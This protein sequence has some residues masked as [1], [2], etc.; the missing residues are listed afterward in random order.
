MILKEDLM[1]DGLHY[2]LKFDHYSFSFSLNRPPRARVQIN[3]RKHPELALFRDEPI[4]E[5]LNLK[6]PALKVF[7][8]ISQRVEE[9]IYKHGIH[10][11]SFSATSTKK[12]NVYEKLL[13][14]WMTRNTMALNRTGIVGDFLFKLGH[15]T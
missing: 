2:I 11:W 13:K 12:A 4:Y 8:A 6:L 1:I 5:D 15:L 9:L 10:Y 7:N 14:R 3:Y